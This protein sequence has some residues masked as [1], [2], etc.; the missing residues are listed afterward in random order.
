MRA[1]ALVRAE[2]PAGGT[3][4]TITGTLTGPHRGRD[5]TLPATA[6][7]QPTATAGLG[8]A[9]LTEPAYWT[10]D[11]PNRYRL[12]ATITHAGGSPVAVDRLVGL[13]R[14]GVRGRSLWLD[15]HRWVPRAVRAE[16]ITGI[17]ACKPAI[18][19]ALVEEPDEQTLA[20]ADEIGVAILALAS[21]TGTHP[22]AVAE[23]IAAWSAHPSVAVAILPQQ[24]PA[25]DVDEVMSGARG[26][27][28]TL[29]LAA[30]VSATSPPPETI[31]S[32]IETLVVAIEP[33]A[34]PHDD[35]R[36]GAPPPL[37][38]WRRQ[39]AAP[40]AGRSPCDALQAA[41]AAWATRDGRDVH[42]WDW[43]GYVVG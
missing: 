2:L 34:I 1:E 9:I 11:L 15:G 39:D 35:W 14:L 40:A 5:T 12:Q 41:L 13:R 37:I 16:G 23:R 38:A 26:R 27:K 43:A 8:R 18:L 30:A 36:A 25:A 17:D 21:G 4:A 42:P 31:P 22:G 7:L 19:A 20:R 29:L 33:D 6:R 3:A 28:D 32:G 24:M 10:P